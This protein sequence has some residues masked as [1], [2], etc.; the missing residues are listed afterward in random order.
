MKPLIAAALLAVLALSAC[1]VLSH[2]DA[3]PDPIPTS[4]DL[5]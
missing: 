5:G 1:T 4:S 3:R 2:Q